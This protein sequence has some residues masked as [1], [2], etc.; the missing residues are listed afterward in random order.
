MKTL[1]L[2]Q[3]R[4]REMG[5]TTKQVVQRMNR[6]RR[7]T[8]KQLETRAHYLSRVLRYGNAGRVYALDLANVL[9]L[10]ASLLELPCLC[11]PAAWHGNAEAS[12]S[13]QGV[14]SKPR[15]APTTARGC[16]QGSRAGSRRRPSPNR[17]EILRLVP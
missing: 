10:D 14:F 5:L 11:W 16:N 13:A 7:F 3:R 8:K 17:I 1:T 12:T 15:D 9:N 6:G 2:P 4:M